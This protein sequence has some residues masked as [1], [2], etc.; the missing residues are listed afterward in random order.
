VAIATTWADQQIVLDGNYKVYDRTYDGDEDA[1]I[2]REQLRMEADSYSES[3]WVVITVKSTNH[4]QFRWIETP[5]GW[6]MIHRSWLVEPAEVSY[7]GVKV[8]A[9][10][11]LSVSMPATWHDGGSVRMATTWID[12]DYGLLPVP[13]DYARNQIV[14]SILAQGTMID[15]WLDEQ[16]ATYE[17][18]DAVIDAGNG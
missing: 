14:K 10:Y 15:A 11:Y 17:D 9:Q 18:L 12:T 2:R 8:N 5:D 3:N 16:L 6:V 4:I 13:E 1:F 7:D